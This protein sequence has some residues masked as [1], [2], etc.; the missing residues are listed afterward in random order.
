MPSNIRYLLIF[1]VFF[2]TLESMKMKCHGNFELRHFLSH[3]QNKARVSV[4]ELTR[5]V[6]MTD[7]MKKVKR[8]IITERG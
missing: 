6:N 5:F 2:V 4:G 7:W 1:A 8:S 3:A